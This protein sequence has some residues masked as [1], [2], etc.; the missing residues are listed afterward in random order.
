M[1]RIMLAVVVIGV[2]LAT[3]IA[4]AWPRL[5]VLG[6]GQTA[7]GLEPITGIARLP[8]DYIVPGTLA[9]RWYRFVFGDAS[10]DRSV[11][12]AYQHKRVAGMWSIEYL[13]D[14]TVFEITRN[15]N[16]HGF[17]SQDAGALLDR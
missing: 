6:G 5:Y 4:L 3:A 11:N 1:R 9:H 16:L 2:L 17:F 12:A 7:P 10:T 15:G 13:P 8:G 14:G